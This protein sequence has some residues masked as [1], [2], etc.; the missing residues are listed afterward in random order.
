[1]RFALIA[2]CLLSVSTFAQST[3]GVWTGYVNGWVNDTPRTTV[4]WPTRFD[5]VYRAP[6][7]S[8]QQYQYWAAQQLAAQQIVVQQ[9]FALEQQRIA[10]RER[11]ATEKAL[12]VQQELLQ[13]EQA[14]AEQRVQLA[15]KQRLAA[16]RELAVQ[17]EKLAEAQASAAAQLAAAAAQQHAAAAQLANANALAAVASAPKGEE[18]RADSAA[19]PA[20]KGPDI[21]RWVDEAGVVHLSTKPPKR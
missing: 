1:M 16:E 20:E 9:T 8:A 2:T 14:L 19:R 4:R 18:R 12:A 10:M 5:G 7:A 15:E 21:H 13:Q 3:G 6:V 11:E 17:Q